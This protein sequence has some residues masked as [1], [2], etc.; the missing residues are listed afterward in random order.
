MCAYFSV[1]VCVCVCVRACA[2]VRVRACVFM[3]M[4]VVCASTCNYL[5]QCISS[6]LTE[7]EVIVDLKLVILQKFLYNYYQQIFASMSHAVSILF[8]IIIL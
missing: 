7:G 3:Y 5:M 1:C 8:A 6:E 2:R 4:C